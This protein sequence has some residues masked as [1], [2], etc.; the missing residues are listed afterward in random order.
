MDMIDSYYL[1]LMPQK[2][3]YDEFQKIIQDL[4]ETYGTPA[5]EPH[6]TLVSGLNGNDNAFV[7]KIDAFVRGKHKFSVTAKNIDYA[8]GFLTALFLNIQN[9]P[10]I[11]QIN[12]QGCEHLKPFGQ[13]PYRPHLSLLYGDITSQ[14]KKRIIADLNLAGKVITFDKIKL[15]K[16]HSD[17]EQWRIIRE[18]GL[19]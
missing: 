8:H 12:A 5:F 16:G 13:D 11:D 3:M 18:W 14:E 6:V 2:E 9:N 19:R 17:V 1:W 10:A 4:S 7:E 15:I